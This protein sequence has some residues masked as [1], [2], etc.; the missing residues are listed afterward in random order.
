MI[1]IWLHWALLLMVLSNKMPRYLKQ[2]EGVSLL[3]SSLMHRLVLTFCQ[4]FLKMISSVLVLLRLIL[5]AK[6][7]ETRC[8]R[9][10]F[11]SVFML[12][13]SYLKAK[14]LYRRT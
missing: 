4:G 12:V 8:L 9:S 1:G 5:L 13:V 14:A 11:L 2:G 6:S 7:Q 10:R 3:P